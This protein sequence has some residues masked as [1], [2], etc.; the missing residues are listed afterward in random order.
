MTE[1][2]GTPQETLIINN[3][4]FNTVLKPDIN[5]P[6]NKN[7]KLVAILLLIIFLLLCGGIFGIYKTIN[8]FDSCEK[9]GFPVRLLDCLGCPKFCDTPWGVTFSKS[10]SIS[11][12]PVQPTTKPTP[13][14]DIPFDWKTYENKNWGYSFKYP[15]EVGLILGRD[16]T[17]N[18]IDLSIPNKTNN[19][20]DKNNTYNISLFSTKLEYQTLKEYVQE[21]SSPNHPVGGFFIVD[22]P[23]TFDITNMSGYTYKEVSFMNPE[24]PYVIVLL[25]LPSGNYLRIRYLEPEKLE[26]AHQNTIDQILFTFKF[27]DKPKIVNVTKIPLEISAELKCAVNEDCGINTCSCQIM[28]KKYIAPEGKICMRECDITPICFQKRCVAKG[29]ENIHTIEI[30]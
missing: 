25:S 6:N 4:S 18:I 5:K 29:N 8:D 13:I 11:S 20:P 22:K 2:L 15:Q 16:D 21:L 14:N 1:I 12:I 17:Q 19:S 7:R 27:I 24:Q 26:E 28:N 9:A 3:E 23:K 30:Q 10:Q